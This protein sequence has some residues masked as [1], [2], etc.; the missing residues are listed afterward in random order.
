[1][2]YQSIA[3]RILVV[4]TLST[5]AACAVESG[6]EEAV[7]DSSEA[8]DA[9]ISD[10]PGRPATS[11]VLPKDFETRSAEAKQQ[12]LWATVSADEYCGGPGTAERPL[13][14][15]GT[16]GC[17]GKLPE[18]GLG[19]YI[20]AFRSLLSLG[21]SF[22]RSSDELPKGR[23]KIFHPFGS[24]AKAELTAS[25]DS[26]YTG[27]F[28][29]AA[30]PVPALVRLAPGGG[31]SFIPGIATKFFV[32]GKPS[33]NTHAIESFDGQGND[34]NYFRA[35][36]TNVVPESDSFLLSTA[37]KAFRLV[38]ANPNHLQLTHIAGITPDG[39]KVASVKEPYQIQYRA[40]GDLATKYANRE[41]VDFRAVLR[42]I[43]PGTV[44]YD[45]FARESA[46][47]TTYAKIGEIKT[48]SWLVASGRGDA[49]L[50]FR[51]F[52]GTN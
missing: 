22:D 35:V 48:T 2:S 49:Q 10:P 6:D 1:M 32:D 9:L 33:V 5:L 3:K 23:H 44:I 29:P 45:V 25:A 24:V 43:P 34:W 50:F 41:H 18:G 27:M 52:R 8:E 39:T 37:T 4:A 47:D 11:A 38:K 15:V 26:P 36:P 46:A 28:A 14:Y 21:T 19:Y 30:A 13:D 12:L 42:S 7:D 20:S 51:H 40:H 31:G 16:R 17:L